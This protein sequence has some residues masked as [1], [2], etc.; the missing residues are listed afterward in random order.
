MPRG[1]GSGPDGFGPMTGRG[2]GYCAGYDRPGYANA[3]YRGRNFRMGFRRFFGGYRHD[4]RFYYPYQEPVTYNEKEFLESEIEALGKQLENLKS[5][6]T[7]ISTKK[8]EK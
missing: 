2:A 3:G 7:Q 5:R 1:D 4:T 6:L 8:Q